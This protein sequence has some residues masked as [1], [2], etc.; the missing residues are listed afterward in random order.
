M[1]GNHLTLCVVTPR[2]PI[3]TLDYAVKYCDGNPNCRTIHQQ[4]NVRN[5]TD[6]HIM[7]NKIPHMPQNHEDGDCS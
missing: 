2:L 6:N 1:H 5:N 3:D 4:I 7:E